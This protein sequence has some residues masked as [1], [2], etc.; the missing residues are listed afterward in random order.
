MTA[1]EFECFLR[2]VPSTFW[3]GLEHIRLPGIAAVSYWSPTFVGS[4][5]AE[6]LVGFRT[7]STFFDLMGVKL[8]RGRNFLSAEDVRGN[9]FVVVL[10]HGFWQRAFGG[11]PG[12]VGKS[13]QLGTRAYTVV[14]IL[15]ADFPSGAL[16]SS[17]P[18]R[19]SGYFLR[20]LAYDETL[21][22]ACPRLPTVSAHR[23]ARL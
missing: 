1:G 16:F 8:E 5:D 10:S 4:H 3:N 7:S 17:I 2:R 13:V 6:T 14:G 22:Y 12:I 15:P 23:L 18:R 9:N 20:P 19:A 21:P 11:D